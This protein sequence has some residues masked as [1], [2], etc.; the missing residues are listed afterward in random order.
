MM[1]EKSESIDDIILAPLR[2]F[3]AKYAILVAILVGIIGVGAI[4]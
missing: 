3:S 1:Y 2:S 4:G